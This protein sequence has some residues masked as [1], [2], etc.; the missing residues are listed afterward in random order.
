MM[1]AHIL[2]LESE[3]RN[4]PHGCELC[5]ERYDCGLALT[6]GRQRSR[7]IQLLMAIA[8]NHVLGDPTSDRAA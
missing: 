4:L 2:R 3:L 6:P 7:L 1:E 8:R 5:S